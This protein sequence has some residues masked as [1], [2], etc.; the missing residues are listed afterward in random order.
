MGEFV[1]FVQAF[2]WIIWSGGFLTAGCGFAA[3]GLVLL[4]CFILYHN[5]TMAPIAVVAGAVG[6]VSRERSAMHWVVLGVYLMTVLHAHVTSH[7][8]RTNMECIAAHNTNIWWAPLNMFRVKGD[9]YSLVAEQLWR[10]V[11]AYASSLCKCQPHTCKQSHPSEEMD[12]R[13]CLTAGF[14][15]SPMIPNRPRGGVSFAQ[16]VLPQVFS[17]PQRMSKTWV[18]WNA[19]QSDAHFALYVGFVSFLAFRFLGKGLRGALSPSLKEFIFHAT[20]QK[21][22]LDTPSMILMISVVMALP[23]RLCAVL[24][25]MEYDKRYIAGEY[26]RTEGLHHMDDFFNTVVLFTSPLPWL[27]LGVGVSIAL[28]I[29]RRRVNAYSYFLMVAVTPFSVCGDMFQ[30]GFVEVPEWDPQLVARIMVLGQGLLALYT[31]CVLHA[32]SHEGFTWNPDEPVWLVLLLC[33]G[34]CAIQ[35]AS[36]PVLVDIDP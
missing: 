20:E 24:G 18:I 15:E 31:W 26:M 9:R 25:L 28:N 12:L 14:N 36:Q 32:H 2:R 3:Y 30:H 6:Y 11:M 34:C 8:S 19:M 27:A 16:S 10:G 33:L 1:T 4:A 35:S 5:P 23:T 29:D 22:L 7:C 17:G 21:S 13:S